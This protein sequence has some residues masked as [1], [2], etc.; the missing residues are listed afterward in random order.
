MWR[1]IVMDIV[2]KAILWLGSNVYG[3]IMAWLLLWVIV[4]M[5]GYGMGKFIWG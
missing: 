3:R 2:I 4:F 5:A 1:E